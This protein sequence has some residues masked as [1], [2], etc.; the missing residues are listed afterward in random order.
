M[1]L[2]S[3]LLLSLT[4]LSS[5]IAQELNFI[6][7]DIIVKLKKTTLV[8]SFCQDFK[9][10]IN[11]EV[12]FIPERC[13]SHSSNLWLLTYNHEDKNEESILSQ[14]RLHKDVII[15]QHNHT[16]VTLRTTE[17]DDT[18]FRNQWAHD[19]TGQF[20]GTIDADMDT[21]EAWDITTGGIT[22]QGDTIVIAIIDGGF[23]LDHPD[24]MPNLWF[25]E[26]EIPDNGI[27]DDSNGYIDDVNGWNAF[28]G[29]GNLP[30][31]FHGTHVA[32]IAGA[33]GNNN[34][35][36][37]GINWDVK[38]MTIAGSSGN[39][40]IVLAAY[41]Y[42]L[43]ERTIYNNTNGAE[44]AFVVATNSSFGVD[45]GDP[46]N[47][48]L[49]CAMYDDLG[50]QG[51]ISATATA[52]LNIDID[53]SG[54]VPTACTSDY[55]IAVTNTTD[56][57]DKR[58]NAGFGK[59]HI[60]L[61]APG[62][63]IISTTPGG[64]YGNLT[65]TSM[66]TPQVAG[67]IGLLM[68]AACDDFITNYKND[69][70]TYAL[71]LKDAIINGTDPISAL[72]GI[73]V[74]GGRLNVHTAILELNPMP[75]G[76]C[77]EPDFTLS[78]TIE[79]RVVCATEDAVFSIDV[80]S[81]SGFSELVTLQ[82]NR[83][84]LP[85]GTRAAFSPNPVTPGN[86]V[87]LV[88]SN[89]GV[90]DAGTYSI[91]I[92]GNASNATP[93]MLPLELTI[94]SDVPEIVTLSAP[95]D[96][97]TS[98]VTN[99]PL[100][101]NT[102]FDTKAYSIDIATDAGF[103]NIIE[104]GT[105]DSTTY[106][107]NNILENSTI[108]YWRV[109]SENSCGQSPNSIAYS[110][111]T[112]NCFSNSSVDT[113]INITFSNFGLTSSSIDITSTGII[114]DLN[115]DLD[116]THMSTSDLIITLISPSGTTAT[117]VNGACEDT[118]DLIGSFDDDGMTLACPINGGSFEPLDSFSVFNREPITGTWVLEIE[119]SF[120]FFG[121]TLNA[122]SLEFC[123]DDTCPPEYNLTGLQSISDSYETDGPIISDQTI[124]AASTVEYN[125]RFSILLNENFE[126]TPGVTFHAFIDGCLD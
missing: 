16:N 50:L 79:N 65:G 114:S 3:T 17:P 126:T 107:P 101:W 23:Q 2:I 76:E 74:S 55:M 14:V 95:S 29:N 7:G 70:G 11:T 52:N 106:I 9:Q 8:E 35:G 113:P 102:P 77:L 6:Q 108:Y 80:E 87:N 26:D 32:G 58:L 31:D 18:E 92:S 112:E 1:K 86:S 104:S 36:V 98:I 51:V 118:N 46:A 49:W 13:L 45:F 47:F 28:G 100:T 44:G 71:A 68:A 89:L 59:T 22:S 109:R 90:A 88:I 66:A 120:L 41:G 25:N 67:T 96:G 124:N 24:L 81:I 60:D 48:P 73:T 93:K 85:I 116:I 54:D 62:T 122:W 94:E 115:L 43:D 78:S 91:L 119:D 84:Q 123:L 34:Q 82:I 30:L 19:N 37:S 39:E 117:I 69:P 33:R 21:P 38:L 83:R 110:F 56:I 97:A 27:D 121:G 53:T 125:S 75:N 15:A 63:N 111:E 64:N 5:I 57:D 4:I 103:A 10:T 42:V 12:D 105:S 61:G 40:A 72:D 20:G 99:T